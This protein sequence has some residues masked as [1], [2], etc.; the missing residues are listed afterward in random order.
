MYLVMESRRP[1]NISCVVVGSLKNEDRLSFFIFIM[2]NVI[3]RENSIM[4]LPHTHHHAQL[5]L[6]VLAV[7]QTLPP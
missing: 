3:R 5:Q 2:K 7:T 1:H 4:M 6:S